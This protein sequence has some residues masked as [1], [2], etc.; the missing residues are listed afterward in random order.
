MQL[1]PFTTGAALLLAA[2][3]CTGPAL[4]KAKFSELPAFCPI[5]AADSGTPGVPLTFDGISR[6]VTDT[7]H[8][9][10]Y[11]LGSTPNDGSATSLLVTG[12]NATPANWQMTLETTGGSAWFVVTYMR[13]NSTNAFEL[14]NQ[15]SSVNTVNGVT[16]VTFNAAGLGFPNTGLVN[17]EFV[18]FGNGN[19]YTDKITSV[20]INGVKAVPNVTS[21]RPIEYCVPQS[22]IP[23]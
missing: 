13:N 22:E 6:F 20:T 7:H 14:T 3:I 21:G 16:T 23:K 11:W 1:K 10:L 2:I 9:A 18:D 12:S 15:L 5:P 8:H 17:L 19:P 4:A